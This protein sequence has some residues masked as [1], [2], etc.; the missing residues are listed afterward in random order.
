MARCE[1]RRVKTCA[2]TLLNSSANDL[3]L[4]R[5]FETRAVQQI[6]IRYNRVQ[7]IRT[8]RRHEKN[9]RAIGKN[10]IFA[11]QYVSIVRQMYLPRHVCVDE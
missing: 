2:E 10:I 5:A 3:V 4:Q 1:S 6:Q 11:V 9:L 8:L 7:S